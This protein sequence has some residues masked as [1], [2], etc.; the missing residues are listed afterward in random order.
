[1]CAD[2]LRGFRKLLQAS[3]SV[4]ECNDKPTTIAPSSILNGIQPLN[5]H[6]LLEY[7]KATNQVCTQPND[8][9]LE[10]GINELHLNDYDEALC[11][12]LEA[13]ETL[14]VSESNK[15]TA[16]VK[17][18]DSIELEK[19]INPMEN[20]VGVSQNI[21]EKTPDRPVTVGGK[22]PNAGAGDNCAVTP[23][24]ETSEIIKGKRG[25]LKVSCQARKQ[26]NFS[27][28]GKPQNTSRSFKLDDVYRFILK[29]DPVNSHCAENDALNLL[30]CIV[31]LGH[32]FTE[33]ADE[34]AI[35]FNSIKKTA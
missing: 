9:A 10:P 13:A 33:W 8:K 30:E 25:H 6:N 27:S 16:K 21:L 2:S 32:S 3:K 11:A 34:N 35:Q 17:V 1:M 26:L 29:R 4:E 31:A 23:K 12:A 15:A 24:V 7:R 22:Y 19:K 5:N 20:E 18:S 14:L 28:K